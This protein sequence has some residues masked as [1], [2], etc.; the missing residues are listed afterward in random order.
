MHYELCIEKILLVIFR[1]RDFLSVEDQ[2]EKI[3]SP[4]FGSG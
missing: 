3:L 4:L 2:I 1:Q